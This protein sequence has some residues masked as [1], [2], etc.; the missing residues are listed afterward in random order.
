MVLE[1]EVTPNVNWIVVNPDTGSSGGGEKVHSVLI[2][3][4][5][6]QIGSHKGVI[7]VQDINTNIKQKI[8]VTLTVR[9]KPPPE[10]GVDPNFLAFVAQVGESNPNS[11]RFTVQNTGEG[12]LR[13]EVEWDANWL[14]VTPTS[15]TSQGASR[16][17]TVAV[18]TTGLAKGAYK[19]TIRITDPEAENSPQEV[20][21]NLEMRED[22][23]PPPPSDDNEI[24]LVQSRSSGGNGTSVTYEVRITGN[25]S[26]ISAFG[27]DLTFDDAVFDYVSTS[28]GSLTGG[29]GSVDGNL[30]S[31]GIVRVGGWGGANAIPIGKTGSI[32]RITLR[33]NCSGCSG[34]QPTTCITN[35]TDD[36]VSMVKKG[37]CKQ[38]TVN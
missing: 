29:W 15:G 8:N 6:M 3:A 30:V 23:P 34:Q 35:F 7:T 36:I 37:L 17:H 11:Q 1:Y 21:V 28:A 2:D 9:D 31:A 10:I 24:S 16:N 13:Y 20:R 18:S 12:T 14:T 38:F 32:V 27:L 25:T 22:P 4:G 33:V 5:G 26:P 19:G